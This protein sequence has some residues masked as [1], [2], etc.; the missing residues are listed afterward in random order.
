MIFALIA[1][2]ALLIGR[3]KLAGWTLLAAVFFTGAV[4]GVEK[5]QVFIPEGQPITLTGVLDG[6]PEFARD[7]VYLTLR[8]E[9][10]LV[11][12]LAPFKS[13]EEY[14]KLN[15]RYGTRIRV[16]TTIARTDSYRNPGV[17]PL[18]EYLERKGY[19][20][21]GVVKSAS[22]ITRLD[23]TRVFP[24][25]AWLYSWRE[26][27]QREIDSRFDPE[28]AGVLDAALL[29]NRYNLSRAA[30]ERFRE[31]GTFHV[32]VISGLHISSSA[33]SCCSSCA[34]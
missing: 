10:G 29:G 19:V 7:R 34:D 25:L 8:V 9:H 18:S 5:R 23:D 1:V 3:L 32:L 33:G 31:G 2:I 20:A 27:L 21:T 6:P 22:S 28:T 30:S 12:L 11:S 24:L 13:E 17:S 4:F 15:L 14:R 16:T 26:R